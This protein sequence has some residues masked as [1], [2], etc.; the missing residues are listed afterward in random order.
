MR[1]GQAAKIREKN[2]LST[3]ALPMHHFS[4]SL[5]LYFLAIFIILFLNFFFYFLSLFLILSVYSNYVINNVRAWWL[6]H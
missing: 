5:S 1:E 4:L 2:I 3:N 6:S